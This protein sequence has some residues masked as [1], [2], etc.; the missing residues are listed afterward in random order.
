MRLPWPYGVLAAILSFVFFRWILPTPDSQLAPAVQSAFNSIGWFFTIMFLLAALFAF[1]REVVN[2]KRFSTT[3]SM[4]EIRSLNWRQFESF[5]G[6][7]FRK[8]GYSVIETPEGPDNGVDLVLRKNGEKT[9]VQCK[10]W[11]TNQVDVEKIRALLGSMAAG[12]AHAGIFVTSGSY[13]QPARQLAR[14]CGIRLID[15]N[16]LVSILEPRDQPMVCLTPHLQQEPDIPLCPICHAAMVKRTAR[17]GRNPG[18]QFWGCSEYP[19]C[20]GTRNF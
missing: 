7:Y 4:A 2:G 19:K 16:K 1:I 6:V 8:Q 20:H 13:T 14:E 18:Q 3:N 15:G 12:G 17:K 10:H 11:K 5:V 9:Y